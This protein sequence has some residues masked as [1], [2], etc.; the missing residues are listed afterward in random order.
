VIDTFLRIGTAI[1]GAGFIG[2]AAFIITRSVITAAI[3]AVV[4]FGVVAW[5]AMKR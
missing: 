2:Y 3:V 5:F 1:L 4:A